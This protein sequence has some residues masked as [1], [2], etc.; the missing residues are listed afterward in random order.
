MAEKKRRMDVLNWNS[1]KNMN[2]GTHRTARFI[3][4]N[5]PKKRKKKQQPK[6]NATNKNLININENGKEK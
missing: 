5:P 3:S 4:I 1:N 6:I 2:Y